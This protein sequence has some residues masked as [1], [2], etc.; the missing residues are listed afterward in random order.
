MPE[1]TEF[2][3]ASLRGSCVE[4]R[5]DHIS[6]DTRTP[7]RHVLAPGASLAGEHATTVALAT[8]T[9]TPEVIAAYHATLED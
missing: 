6:G 1:T 4:V 7:H 2:V 9:W 8:A 3:G 5:V